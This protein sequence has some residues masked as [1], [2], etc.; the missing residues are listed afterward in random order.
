MA[1]IRQSRPDSDL[2]SYSK[3]LEIFEGVPS[4][5]G[6]GKMDSPGGTPVAFKLKADTLNSKP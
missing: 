2:G 3:A 4:S 5:L 6:S 1:L